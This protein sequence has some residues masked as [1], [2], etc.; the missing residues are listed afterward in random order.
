MIEA[1]TSLRKAALLIRSLD[2]DSAAVL[3][4]QLSPSEAKTV[5]MA[6]QDLGDFEPGEQSAIRDELQRNAKSMSGS[7]SA[8]ET[9][10][11]QSEPNPVSTSGGVELEL[12]FDLESDTDQWLEDKTEFHFSP[13]TTQSPVEKAAT[14]APAISS[15]TQPFAW[16]EGG[17]LPAAAMM[18]QRE[19]LSTVAVV[20]SYLPAQ[21]AGELLTALPHGRRAAALERLADLGDSD[22][23]SLEVIEKELADWIAKR[24]T[25]Q[26]RQ[27][28]RL[29]TVKAILQH[30]SHEATTAVLAEIASRDRGLANRLKGMPNS[31]VTSG[32]SRIS[33]PAPTRPTPTHQ[34][35]KR[36]AKQVASLSSQRAVSE[37]AMISSPAP[38]PVV[39]PTITFKPVPPAPRF[40][41]PHLTELSRQDIAKLF[42]HCQAE[43]L[44][45]ALA[46]SSDALT[47]HVTSHLPR[48]VGKELRRRIDQLSTIRL[49]DVTAAQ[50]Q[51]GETAAQLIVK[52]QLSA[53]LTQYFQ[54]SIP[55]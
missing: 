5:R 28:N 46:G 9:T 34:A 30:S 16:L 18:L 47:K 32:S 22:R 38:I 2:A 13:S 1:P 35:P 36:V 12:P 24:K 8:V 44:V 53:K 50:E 15:A 11:V 49:L 14:V 51:I 42:Q 7:A 55:A 6:I 52:G 40:D 4:G 45:L 39:A 25:E 17:D 27:A 48:T 43:Q 37:S 31:S 41:F 10:S 3:L 54:T 26:R 20:L 29:E 23:A 21:Q 33:P 19:H